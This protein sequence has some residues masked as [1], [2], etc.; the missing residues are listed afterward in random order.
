MKDHLKGQEDQ[1]I[2]PQMVIEMLYELSKGDAF[3]TTGVGQH[4]MWSGQWY[5][6]KFPAPVHHER[7]A[8]SDGLRISR[9]PRG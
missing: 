6:Y 2:L 8:R 1:V 7:R 4:Q 5:K 3:I 9:R